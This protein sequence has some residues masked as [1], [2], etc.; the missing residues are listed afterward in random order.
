[1]R[2]ARHQVSGP[3]FTLPNVISLLRL[4]LAG[5]AVWLLVGGHR[6]AAAVAMTLAFLTD[7]LDGALARWGHS[8]SE[9]GKI[10]D[11]LCDKLVFAFIGVSLAVL[12]LVPLWVVGLLVGRDLFVGGGGILLAVRRGW[13][14]VANAF[15]KA[16]TFLM[17]AWMLRRAFWPP[18]A[19][20]VIGLDW[21]GVLAVSVLIVSTIAY[22]VRAIRTNER[23]PGSRSGGLVQALGSEGL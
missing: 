23:A 9:W 10:L 16:S 20:V 21:L 7:A 18:D 15:G 2:W 14:P 3:F 4:P 1:M 11:P 6:S 17:A 19:F 8:V 12:H 22:V 13:T 5:L